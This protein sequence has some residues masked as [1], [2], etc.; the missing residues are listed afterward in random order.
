MKKRLPFIV[1]LLI[2]SCKSSNNSEAKSIIITSTE[3]ESAV[4]YLA[5]DERQGRD[6]G[7]PGIAA[8]A[9][10]I[11][12]QFKTFGVKPYFQSYRD[13]FDLNGTEAFNVVGFLEGT[14]PTLKDEVIVLGAHYDHIG[15]GKA[16]AGDSIANGANDNA[17]GTSTVMAIAKYFAAKKSNKRSII[18][19]LFSA[20]EKGLRGS[21][22][23]S[24]SLQS[25]GLNLYTMVNFEMIGVPMKNKEYSAYITGFEMS[26]MAE[27]MNEYIG[28]DIIGFL[29]QAK[30][31]RLFMRSD[32]YPFFNQFNVPCQTISTFDFTNYN[33]YHHVNDEPELMD[34]EHMAS[35]IN[36]IIPAV[37]QMSTTPTK[38]IAMYEQ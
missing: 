34:Y 26:N 9:D 15:Q 24:E 13:N 35:L 16:V 3:L 29:P 38:E 7:S 11:S 27:K 23:L 32:N 28:S 30:E 33:Y 2:L 18:F 20:E 8:A 21:K 36:A 4:T 22:H 31:Y 19:A 37:E 1:L 6:T 5:A 12:N 25:S 17:A 14:D 10:Y